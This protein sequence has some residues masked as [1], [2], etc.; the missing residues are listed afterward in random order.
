MAT[1]QKIDASEFRE[2]QRQ[3]WDGVATGWPL[4]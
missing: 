2:Q 4:E 1:Q 3:Q